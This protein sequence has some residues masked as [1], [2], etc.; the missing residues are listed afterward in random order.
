MAQLENRAQEF[1]Y[2][3]ID[4]DFIKDCVDL[5]TTLVGGAADFVDTVGA[6]PA[7]LTTIGGALAFKNVG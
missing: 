1:W 5:L 7:I 2:N 4:S 6:L 3:L